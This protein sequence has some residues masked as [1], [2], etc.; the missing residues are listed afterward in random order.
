MNSR[1]RVLGTIK[2]EA[3]DRT[4]YNFR[5]ED[6]T[7]EKLFR[8]TP[9]KNTDILMDA[10]NSDIRHLNAVTPP[11]KNMGGFF[12]N[13]WGERY[14]YKPSEYGPVREDMDGALSKAKTLK[15]LKDFTWPK[16]DDFDYS[17]IG[18]QCN[19]YEGRAIL[20]GH[21]DIWQ[22]PSLVRG[23]ANFFE[24]MALNPEFCHYICNVF[25]DFYVEEYRR[26]YKASGG[27]I[28]IFLIYS[29]LG[30]QRSPFISLEMLREFVV[31]YIK[32]IAVAIHELGAYFF[33]HSCGMIHTFIPDLIEAG[34]DILDPIQPCTPSMQPEELSREFGKKLSF[35]G[36]IDVQSVLIN[37]TPQNVH[38][39]VARYKAAFGSKGYICSS[40]HL[41]QA[42]TPV[43]NILALFDEI[44]GGN[45]V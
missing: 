22:R 40:S 21:G 35:H 32:R 4:P 24:D 15:E 9:Y 37:G 44:R 3:T 12:Q 14:I 41:L 6:V 5:A 11:E 25:T 17:L 10:L 20:Y 42:D 33:Y 38:D 1:E 29:D 19:K 16:N 23:M 34:V 43:E 7:L 13:Y 39:E 31:P 18:A 28:D 26:A 27:R 2:H 8:S 45:N 30:G 36:G